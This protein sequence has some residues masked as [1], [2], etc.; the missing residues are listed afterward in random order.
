MADRALKA[1]GVLFDMDGVLVATEALKARAHSETVAGL[2]GRL[3]PSYYSEVMGQSHYLAAKAFCEA[4]GIPF[5][6]EVYAG[7]FMETYGELLERGVELI[8]GAG[9]LVAAV[10]RLGY[11]TAVVSSS[12]RW[13]M[14]VV[15]AR[16]GLGEQFDARISADDVEEEKPSPEPYLRALAELSLAP[17]RAV[18]I[19]DTESGV[20]SGVAAGVP[21]IAVRH[22][23]NGKHD[24]SRAVAVLESLADAG[25]VVRVVRTVLEDD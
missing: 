23:Y 11:R 5:E 10:Q 25:S 14:D 13:M 6:H 21:V 7:L 12:L 3:D 18:I 1:K 2:G 4:G 22:E 15:L 20:A 9:E 8:P 24:L 16:T 19:E 17:D